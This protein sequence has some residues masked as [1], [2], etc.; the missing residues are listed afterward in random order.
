MWAR[1]GRGEAES[2]ANAV[3]E[4]LE[5][6]G[7]VLRALPAHHFAQFESVAEKLRSAADRGRLWLVPLAL[8]AG[9]GFHLET[10]GATAVGFGLRSEHAYARTE[11]Q[12]AEAATFA[13]AVADPTRL[14]LLTMVIRYPEGAMTLGDL[15]R[16]L[17]VRQPTVSGHLK[18]LRE[19]GLIT[20]ERKGNRT[21]PRVDRGA[22]RAAVDL[23]D[24][25][26]DRP[27]AD[28]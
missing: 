7:D 8:A 2:A 12:V 13:R 24:E 19:A 18:Q 1:Q 11:R 6:H 5:A 27:I 15:A 10:D 23:L 9:G 26:L 16:Q 25:V 22:L 17:G 28:A 3:R 4:G 20:T 14:H 21:V